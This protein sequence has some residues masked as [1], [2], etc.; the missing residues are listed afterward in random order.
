MIALLSKVASTL[1]ILSISNY[2]RSPHVRIHAG[3]FM[4]KMSTFKIKNDRQ[5]RFLIRN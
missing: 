2:K 4:N 3:F 5:H 1:E